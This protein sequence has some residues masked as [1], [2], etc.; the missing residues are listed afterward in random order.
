MSL[1]TNYSWSDLSVDI[2]SRVAERL[3][4]I[5]LF[6]FGA[7]C[8][9]WRACVVRVRGIQ[10]APVLIRYCSYQQ[11]YALELVDPLSMRLHRIGNIFLQGHQLFDCRLHASKHGWLL[12]S[13]PQQEQYS[14]FFY[15]PLGKIMELPWLN[16]NMDTFNKQVDVKVAATFS[17]SPTCDDC[18]I[19]VILYKSTDGR[20][21]TSKD[22]IISTCNLRDNRWITQK[23]PRPNDHEVG[24]LAYVDGVFHCVF[25]LGCLSITFATFHLALADWV[26]TDYSAFSKLGRKFAWKCY[27]VES[28][29]ELLFAFYGVDYFYDGNKDCLYWHIYQFDP[30]RK[31]WTRLFTLGSRAL[32]IYGISSSFTITPA[33]EEIADKIFY[34]DYEWTSCITY[35]SRIHKYRRESIYSSSCCPKKQFI[36]LS[37]S[38]NISH[39][40]E[41][42]AKFI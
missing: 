24:A 30:S 5:D 29:G 16:L 23:Y 2:L 33:K 1:K 20:R 41:S 11:E 9:I 42:I 10:Y 3:P 27:L 19:F 14:F 4:Y 21:S 7:V 26:M 34:F 38:I 25:Y 28:G 32:L 17:T 40:R 22:C 13:K 12:F 35:P 15:N 36:L 6:S 31:D 18:V 39:F 37:L 8:K